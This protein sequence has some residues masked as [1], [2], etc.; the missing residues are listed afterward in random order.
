VAGHYVCFP[1]R[2]EWKQ[3]VDGP[4]TADVVGEIALLTC[5]RRAAAAALAM[6]RESLVPTEVEMACPNGHA[7]RVVATDDGGLTL[8]ST[9]DDDASEKHGW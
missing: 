7:Y 4:L 9:A 2:Q 8:A 5:G 6:T 3:R 1:C